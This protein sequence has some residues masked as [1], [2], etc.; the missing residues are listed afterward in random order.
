MSVMFGR[1]NE[2]FMINLLSFLK[3][4]TTLSFCFPKA[5][6]FFGMTNSDAFH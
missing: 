5:S 1:G 4:T 2:S 3:S 6:L